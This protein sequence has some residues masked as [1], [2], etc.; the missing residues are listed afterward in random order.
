MLILMWL[1]GFYICSF[2]DVDSRLLTD[3]KRHH[4]QS[5]WNHASKKTSSSISRKHFQYY[6]VAAKD[7]TLSNIHEKLIETSYNTDLPLSR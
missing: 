5:Y 2:Q 3:Y 4:I 6:K 1:G 7:N